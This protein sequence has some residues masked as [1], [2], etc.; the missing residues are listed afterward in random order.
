MWDAPS[1][2]SERAPVPVW[3]GRFF[4]CTG[5]KNLLPVEERNP[6]ATERH[7]ESLG[8]KMVV[9]GNAATPITQEVR[10]PGPETRVCFTDHPL[11]GGTN[12]V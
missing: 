7:P 5:T 9:K 4:L 12:G 10:H 6:L 1:Q 2:L 8:I 11:N 3:A